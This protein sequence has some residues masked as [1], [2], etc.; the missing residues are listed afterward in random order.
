MVQSSWSKKTSCNKSSF[1]WLTTGWSELGPVVAE[2]SRSTGALVSDIEIGK[3][4]L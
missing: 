1:K 4:T 3:L 2:P